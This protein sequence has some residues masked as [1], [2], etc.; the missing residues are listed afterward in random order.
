MNNKALTV[1]EVNGYIKGLI[2]D[3]RHLTCIWIKGEISNCTIH[4]SGHIYF[5][6]KDKQSSL[7]AVMFK[8]KAWKLNFHPKNGMDVLAHGS[9][10][11]YER[12][13]Q[14]QLYVDEIVS[15]GAGTLFLALEELKNRLRI[16]GLFA[17]ERKK[18]LPFLPK[19]V[20]IV[21]S[22]TG[23]AL[24]D[25]VKVIKRRY[26]GMELI[27]APTLVQGDKAPDAISKAIDNLNKIQ[28][29]DCIIVARGGGSLEELMPFNSELVA[30]SIARSHKPIISAIGHETDTTIADLAA[31]V[32]AA[33]PS[34]AGEMAVPVLENLQSD[35]VKLNDRLLK[36][37]KHKLTTER[38]RTEM[39][40]NRAVFQRPERMWQ[41]KRQ[42]VDDLQIR[43]IQAFD[44]LIQ[45]KR[46][47]FELLIGKL[48]SLSPLATLARGY[49]IS[50]NSYGDLIK[51]WSQVE[52][53][54]KIE[55]LLA[56][57]KL[58]CFVEEACENHDRR[59]W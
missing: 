31:D 21:S 38:I 57:G 34:M 8:S 58:D 10:S 35:M 16:E 46:S 50:R 42:Y 12:D 15:A 5:S 2:D 33:T 19:A 26:P 51:S 55:I 17:Q 4:S 37:I 54:Q 24:R 29:V 13:G 23:A 3:N 32:R 22:P 30:R 49:S 40:R 7:K 28:E 14:F 45:K 1:S 25:I 44:G 20:G 36:G 43:M 18:K 6:L 53:G 39:I 47:G 41:Q 56:D 27:L 48:N 52:L 11:V 9:F 59:Q